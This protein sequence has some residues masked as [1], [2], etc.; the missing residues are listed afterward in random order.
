MKQYRIYFLNGDTFVLTEQEWKT[1]MAGTDRFSIRGSREGTFF[2]N[3]ITHIVSEDISTQSQVV[4]PPSPRQLQDEK[5]QEQ[6]NQPVTLD[7]QLGN[8]DVAQ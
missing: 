1:S 5:K 4:T 2:F 3:N 8:P 6:A 7:D